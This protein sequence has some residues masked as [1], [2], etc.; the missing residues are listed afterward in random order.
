ML[1]ERRK[2]R[3]YTIAYPVESKNG[4]TRLEMLTLVDVSKGGIAFTSAE[5][6][7]ENERVDLQLFLK[8]RMFKLKAIVVHVRRL[9][10][11]IYNVGVKFLH[12]PEEFHTN[13]D[14][15]IEEIT[16][17][18]RECNLYNHKNISFE[19][20]STEYLKNTPLSEV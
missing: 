12:I 6:P 20:A 3:R 18:H 9:K 8:N 10:E 14:K 1:K 19:K 16:Q 13:L 7:K 4:S 2:H 5:R 15:E 11:N 17:F